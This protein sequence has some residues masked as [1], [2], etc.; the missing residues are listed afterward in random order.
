MQWTL[1]EEQREGEDDS[2]R[3]SGGTQQ[4]HQASYT[5]VLPE[6]P[7]VSRERVCLGVPAVL[8]LAGSSLGE[9]FSAPADQSGFLDTAGGHRSSRRRVL[10]PAAR[11]LCE[12]LPQ[13][14][15]GALR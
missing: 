11:S 8:S 10:M 5:R 13:P 1:S 12:D 6:E 14:S 2:D 3:Q 9:V 4:G 15:P 7:C